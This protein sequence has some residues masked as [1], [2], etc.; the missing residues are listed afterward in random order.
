MHGWIYTLIEIEINGILL[1][2]S[3]NATKQQEQSIWDL[4]LYLY[5]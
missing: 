5:S 4:K 3:Y 2:F 1:T